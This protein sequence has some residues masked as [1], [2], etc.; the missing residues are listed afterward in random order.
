LTSFLVSQVRLQDFWEVPLFL[1]TKLLDLIPHRTG[2]AAGL[3]TGSPHPQD[4]SKLLDLIPR[5]KG[6]AAGLL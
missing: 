4:Y 5:L 2:E 3:L 1:R 6:E